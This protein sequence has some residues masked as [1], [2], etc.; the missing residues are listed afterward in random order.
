LRNLTVERLEPR[1]VLG[2]G[3]LIISEFLAINDGGRTDSDGDHS[4]WIEIHN[5]TD[6]PIDLDGWYL[7]DDEGNLTK[8]PFPS[9]SLAAHEYE[10]VFA[11][12]KNRVEIQGRGAAAEL[13][14]NF[15]LDGDGE[16]LAL[17]ESDGLGGFSASDAYAPEFPQQYEDISYGPIA[18]ATAFT[19][20]VSGL[21]YMIP[22]NI[23]APLGTTWTSGEFDDSAWEGF[24]RPP[25][26]LITEVGTVADFAEIANLSDEPADTAGWVV[27]ANN[28]TGRDPSINSVHTTLWPLPN[29]IEPGEVLYRHDDPEEDPNHQTY[30]DNYW[31]EI[32]SWKTTGPG[33][34]MIVDGSGNVRDFVVWEY[35]EAE[36]ATLAVNIN[37]FDVTADDAWSGGSIESE[38]ARDYSLQRQGNADNDDGNDWAFVHGITMGEENEALESP[39][40]GPGAPSIGFE[41][42]P[43]GSEDEIVIDVA[44]VMYEA[45]SSIWTRIPFEVDEP[46]RLET[47]L[48]RMKYNDGFVA[49]I[50]GHEV[51][52]QN[53]PQPPLWNS[54]ATESVEGLSQ[55][56]E[57]E[58]S[59]FIGVLQEGTNLLAIHGLNADAMDN[60]F[61]LSPELAVTAR[62]YFDPPTPRGAN[63]GNFMGFVKDTQFDVDRG[64][65]YEPFDLTITSDTSGATIVYTLDGSLP[66]LDLDGVDPDQTNGIEYTGPV[67]IDGTSALRVAAFKKGYRP[68]NADTQTYVF[69]DQINDQDG[70]GF[71]TSWG[72]A[73][74]DYRLDG[75]IANVS[76]LRTIPTMSLV[77]ELDD[78]WGA[79]G[80]YSNPRS[81]GI[82]WERPVSVEYI[83]PEGQT[84]FQ[85]DAGVRIHGGAGRNPSN[86]KHSLRLQFKGIYGPTKLDY[87]MFG[88]EAV[89][90]FDTLVL[91]AGWNDTWAPGAGSSETYIQ[92]RWAAQSQNDLGGWGPHGN[93]VHLYINGLYWGLYNP[94]ERPNASFG[95]SYFGGN[96]DDYDA[97][98]TFGL[99]DGT[100]TAWNQ[101]ISTIR[102]YPINYDAVKQI[103]DVPSFIN[104]QMVNQYGGNWDWPQN[105]WYA[106]RH[107]TPEGLWRFHSWDAEGC[108]SDVNSNR[109]NNFRDNGPG[110]VDQKL[111]ANADF[112]MDFAD[113]VHRNL[114]N[115][116]QLTSEANIQRINEMASVIDRAIVGEAARWGHGMSRSD[117]LNRIN[118]L[119]NT[120]FPQ[121]TNVVLNQYRSAGLYP[122]LHAPEFGQHGGQVGPGY[123]LELHNANNSGLVYYMLDGADP[124]LPGGAL[125]PDALLY[126]DPVILGDSTTAIARVL[127]AG[128]WSASTEAKFFF[129]RPATAENLVIT[130]LNYNPHDPTADE[131]AAGYSDNDD[132]EFVELLNTTYTT[133]FLGGL[134][135][136][137]G[138]DFDFSA[139]GVQTLAAGQRVVVARNPDAFQARY[140][141][142]INVVGP[143]DTRLNN[144]G[145]RLV[146]TDRFDEPIFDF[147][148]DNGGDW[149][150]RADGNGSSLE[151]ST[152]AFVPPGNPGRNDYVAN[153]DNWRSS[154]EYGGSP[155]VEG[156]GPCDDVLINEVLTHTDLPHVDGIELYN[157]TAEPIDVGGWYLSDSNNPYRKFPIPSTTIGADGYVVFDEDDFNPLVPVGES[158]GF[159]LSGAHGDEVWLLEADAEGRLIRFVDH[160]EFPA[161][162]NGESLGRWPDGSGDLYPMV[163]PTLYPACE[164]SGPR[165]GPIIISELQYN[166]A[167]VPGADDLE[168]VE[169]YNTTSTIVN[170]TNWRIRKGIDFDFPTDTLLGPHAAL[171]VVPF[172]LSEAE[173]LDDFCDHYGIGTDTVQIVGGYRDVLDNGGEKVQLQRPDDPPLDEP[174]FIPRL[175]ED[176]VR[177]Y[178]DLPWPIDADGTGRSLGRVSSDAWGND[179][180]GWVD[181]TPSPGTVLAAGEAQV[182]GHYVFY[183]NSSG[184]GSGDSTIAPDKV[185]L[186][187]GQTAG[188][189][190]YTSFDRGINGVMVDVAG[191]PDG[192]ALGR[193]DFEF[194]VGNSDDPGNW[195]EAP[196]PIS[197]TVRPNAGYGGSARVTLTWTDGAIKNQWLQVKV[198]DTAN[199]NL[200][201]PEVFYFGNAVGESGNSSGNSSGD[202][203]VNAADILLTRNNG[204]NLLNPAPIDFRYD[205]NRDC[206]VNAT[207]M[208]IA[209]D[210]Q[211]HLLNALRLINAPDEGATAKRQ[212]SDS[213]FSYDL[214]Y[215]AGS[216]NRSEKESSLEE[217]IDSLLADE[218]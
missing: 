214:E 50:N 21:R 60:D 127:D 18:D 70:T 88:D 51:A 14:T 212:Q 132:F 89:D 139:S 187:P 206:R 120:Y 130:E 40:S 204:R 189:A 47:M 39:F 216:G 5:P 143:Y 184:F 92:D 173:K 27:A 11:S 43:S 25:M 4:D 71:P 166:P 98:R 108:I 170:L 151:L 114:F 168:F 36:I 161:A 117:W 105:N 8:W 6:A 183:N 3:P 193:S 142:G 135:F 67:T 194:H 137:A 26:V 210:N 138:I 172:E 86:P 58:L 81:E 32:I 215:S 191:F 124:R 112:R 74:A 182:V 149:P 174:G 202:A 59:R 90:S 77:M 82:N 177:Y 179:A 87:P 150:G 175:L 103:V 46:G 180:A 33:W 30:H 176:E 15:Q 160:V 104:Y 28:A 113:A 95:A 146:L 159:A 156:Q 145:E 186:R 188:F 115:D 163:E 218:I 155:G 209:R 195:S 29:S 2:A 118:W 203:K 109:V 97:Y 116:G 211:T 20:E 171:V 68:S 167:G 1:L 192:V 94:V 144:N 57:I 76:D 154:S 190:N 101:L 181:T 78:L 69:L 42:T 23:H 119:R 85:V 52:R 19:L 64:F 198:L 123:R 153:A 131:I 17:I 152:P 45:N 34:V 102:S 208:L 63:T 79:S 35:S 62:Q 49:Y 134:R 106:T 99:I 48:L 93:F 136:T 133:I 37:G 66:Y 125:N 75:Q 147:V 83:S 197:V 73:S 31:G 38:G 213:F 100:S 110:E 56:E 65:Y 148:Y 207:D 61:F 201:S 199:T 140:G 205:F 121:R 91:R 9:I 13:H 44:H 178:D 7:T 80:I 107:R 55:Y 157:A 162:I 129:D 200:P 84:E 72:S 141:S 165:V 164:N 16:Y 54:A 24:Q 128:K 10:I 217:A 12:G 158:I 111:R 53:A 41:L 22:K 96:K 169:I 196:L 122:T 185:P 126:S